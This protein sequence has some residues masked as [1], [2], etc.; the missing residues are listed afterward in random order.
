MIVC[1]SVN[2]MDFSVCGFLRMMGVVVGQVEVGVGEVVVLPSGEEEPTGCQKVVAVVEGHEMGHTLGVEEG[3]IQVADFAKG[4]VD[5]G[6]AKGAV[7]H[8][9]LVGVEV[10]VHVH[11]DPGEDMVQV[12]LGEEVVGDHHADV[13]VEDPLRVPQE[14]VRALALPMVEH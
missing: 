13:G 2:S 5:L 10:V 3:H 11:Q 8:S 12:P 7:D 4:V 9:M 14:G 6:F 1:L